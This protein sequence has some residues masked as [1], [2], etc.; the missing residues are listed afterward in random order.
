MFV[1]DRHGI[2]T[3]AEANTG[4]RIYAVQ[5]WVHYDTWSLEEVLCRLH[6]SYTPIDLSTRDGLPMLQKAPGVSWLGV[7]VYAAL[8]WAHGGE[9]LPT[10]WS[11]TMLGLFCILLPVLLLAW[12]SARRLAPLIGARDAMVAMVV[13][14]AA[15]PLFVYG[16]LFM[17]YGLATMLL[18]GGALLIRSA[19][20]GWIVLGGLA[21][22]FAGDVNYVFWV[23]GAVVGA[24]E[25][26]R[27]IRHGDRPRD[28]FVFCLAGAA[29]PLV[30]LLV[31][32]HQMWG[33]V[34]A[35]GY[36]FMD[37]EVHRRRSVPDTPLAMLG[38]ALFLDAKH[39][40]FVYAPWTL[41]GVGGLVVAWRREDLRWHGIT[42]AAVGLVA[43][44]FTS[45]WQAEFK[46]DAAFSRHMLPAF[47]WL[48][49]GLVVFLAEAKK[50]L[51][52]RHVL[53]VMLRD[54]AGALVAIS[55]C[56]QYVTGWTFPYHPMHL[57]SPVWQLN[58]PLFT[59]GVH[60]PLVD[61]DPVRV[62]GLDGG[63]GH[64]GWVA[65]LALAIAV[66]FAVALDP[67][68]PKLP[69]PIPVQIASP[70]TAIVAFV[71]LAFAGATTDP[72]AGDGR[73]QAARLE[74]H[75]ASGHALSDTERAMV[76]AARIDAFWFKKVAEEIAGSYITRDDA[77]WREEGYRGRSPWCR[78]A[79]PP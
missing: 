25:F 30:A 73:A 14:L 49:L 57:P 19:H 21:L 40:I 39:G 74:Q 36:D 67:K 20:R 24:V 28:F 7:P 48:A 66:A 79:G 55:V 54:V 15:S 17:D 34:F 70:L 56:T 50:R 13:L 65:V 53:R 68:R 46:D 63:Y 61:L 41:L 12:F 38:K 32:N 69:I 1:P 6:G 2:T 37:H 43:L 4:V 23:H 64:W 22:G 77:G 11:L 71:L 35:T 52:S 62:A 59:N 78:V 10:H 51:A 42:G 45:I 18:L 27:R 26:A 72:L 58:L 76:R 75:A 29:V 3:I 44:G 33:S 5:S 9:R 16:S 60:G 47:P 8:S 31:Y